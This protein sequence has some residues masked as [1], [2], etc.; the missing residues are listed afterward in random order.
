MEV[1]TLGTKQQ[2]DLA[3]MKSS[4]Y[5][6]IIIINRQHQLDNNNNKSLSYR[7]K[8]G[9][10]IALYNQSTQYQSNMTSTTQQA[11]HGAV[12]KGRCVDLCVGAVK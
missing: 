9:T 12:N 11:Q 10:A 4:N 3:L 8:T 5:N 2:L 6:N 7:T 1:S